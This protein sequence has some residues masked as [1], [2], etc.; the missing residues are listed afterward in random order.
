[1]EVFIGIILVFMFLVQVYA[2][3]LKKKAKAEVDPSIFVSYPMTKVLEDL[4]QEIYRLYII[5]FHQIFNERGDN[6]RENPSVVRLLMSILDDP[7]SMLISRITVYV[8]SHI[9][10]QFIQLLQM[11]GWRDEVIIEHM[12]LAVIGHSR[13]VVT[14]FTLDLTKADDFEEAISLYLEDR[15][16]HLMNQGIRETK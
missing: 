1:M 16:Y 8:R 6:G 14:K 13:Q 10:Q 3:F 11:M 15:F 4:N 9:P 12:T 5:R 2:T 7:E